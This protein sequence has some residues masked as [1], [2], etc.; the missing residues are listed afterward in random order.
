[1]RITI[2]KIALDS[3]KTIFESDYGSYYEGGLSNDGTPSFHFVAFKHGVN[4]EFEIH[5]SD[6]DKDC[7]KKLRDF[8]DEL[9]EDMEKHKKENKN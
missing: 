9:L 3:T 1:M 2:D 6:M 8:F 5:F 7:I 4:E